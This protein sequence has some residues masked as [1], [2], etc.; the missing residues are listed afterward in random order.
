[1]R[2]EGNG[3]YFHPPAALTIQSLASI[4]AED[5]N[6]RSF[7]RGGYRTPQLWQVHFNGT[8]CS[9]AKF[10]QERDL[11]RFSLAMVDQRRFSLLADLM[12]RSTAMH[13]MFS[14]TLTVALSSAQCS[15]ARVLL[16]AP[17]STYSSKVLPFTLNG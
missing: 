15:T 16:P 4:K 8:P 12:R 3:G 10:E 9:E 6:G 5:A 11:G 7:V 13:R 2:A 14:T 1:M 17:G